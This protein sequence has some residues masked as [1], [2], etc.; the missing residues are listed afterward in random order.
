MEEEAKDKKE[1]KRAAKN[2]AEEKRGQTVE[3]KPAGSLLRRLTADD[4]EEIERPQKSYNFRAIMGGDLLTKGW[5]RKNFWYIV[6]VVL[7]TIVYVSGRPYH[8]LKL[9]LIARGEK[10][11]SRQVAER[12]E[13]EAGLR[14][15]KAVP[16]V[17]TEPE[18]G[19]SI[20]EAAAPA[21]LRAVHVP[22]SDNDAGGMLAICF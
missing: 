16:C 12:I 3:E 19:E 7:M 1:E 20:G 6:M 11:Q 21:A 17:D 2:A 18:I 15:G 5:F 14:V 4:Q 9:S 10:A 22:R 8:Q 13:A